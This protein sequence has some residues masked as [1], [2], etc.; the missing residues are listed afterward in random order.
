MWFIPGVK[1]NRTIA[2]IWWL[3][4]DPEQRWIGNLKLAPDRSPEL[5][6]TVES[7]SSSNSVQYPDVLH[8]CDRHGKPITLFHLGRHNCSSASAITKLKYSAGYALPGVKLAR[9]DELRAGVLR[10][11]MQHLFEWMARSAF[12]ND[13][14]GWL[15]GTIKYVCPQPISVSAGTDLT[16]KIVSTSGAWSKLRK[17]GVTEDAYVEFSSEK[18][19]GFNEC[20]EF[21]TAFRHLLHFAS[22]EAVYP[23]RITCSKFDDPKTLG[24]KE[25]EI[26]SSVYR[27]EIESE[28]QS[29]WWIFQL[30]DVQANLSV[31]LENW[32][33]AVKKYEEALG[34]YFTTVYFSLPDSIQHICLTQAL[35][36]FHGIKNQALGAYGFEKHIK[37]LAETYGPALPSLFD[38]PAGLAKL[39]TV[40]RH[41]YTHFNPKDLAGGAATGT[42]LFHLN[43][44]LKLL[45]QMCILTEM[46]IPSARFARLQRQLATH[47]VTYE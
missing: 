5:R 20:E 13:T 15:E 23:T 31:F 45:F 4:D 19:F 14:V 26:V 21:V 10:F 34:C 12:Q 37:S 41:Y 33:A 17:R 6:L 46:G 11:H 24:G 30:P 42:A 2:G 39:T 25:A 35:L 29:A 22:L 47:V 32:L 1:Q 43:E 3:P 18:K 36:A 38:D 7:S 8:G 40:T 16:V 28:F 9:R 44:K 27:E